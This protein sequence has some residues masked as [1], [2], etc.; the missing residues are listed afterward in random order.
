MPA[1]FDPVARPYR[2]LEYLSFGPMLERCRFCRIPQL[3]NARRALV[4]GD[5][6]GRFLAKLL[7]ANPALHAD[8]VDQSR[9]ML[10]L[11]QAR[12]AAIGAGDRIRI[13]QTDAV[14]FQP[15]GQP[16]DLVVTH[17]FLDCF[18]GEEVLALVEKIRP[19][20]S[21]NACWLISE[22][23]IPQGIAALA[24]KSAV[25][26]L[27]AAF[28]ILTGLRT[29]NLPD[30]ASVLIRSGFILENRRRFLAGLL[31]SELWSMSR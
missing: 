15:E 10:R 3:A 11:L 9:A 2:W 30:Y 24:A 31:V 13:H 21:E 17:F 29:R 25:A 19:C 8:V 27:Y 22:F 6:D 23:A 1:N 5:G 28:R 7:A 14:A 4:L 26:S 18:T 12:V 16:Y 20:L